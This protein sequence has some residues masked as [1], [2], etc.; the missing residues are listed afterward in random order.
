MTNNVNLPKETKYFVNFTLQQWKLNYFSVSQILREINFGAFSGF[1]IAIFVV[2]GALNFN[3]SKLESSK[4]AR[5][6]KFWTY[7]TVWVP[8]CG[9]ALKT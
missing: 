8:Q 1:D 7:V 4:S 5:F 2:L 6:G 9:K 3:T